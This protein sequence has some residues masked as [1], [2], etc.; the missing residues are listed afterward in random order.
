MR[1]IVG[2]ALA[3]FA[4]TVAVVLLTAIPASAGPG[5]AHRSTVSA[6][7]ANGTCTTVGPDGQI[8]VSAT[9]DRSDPACVGQAL[10]ATV[11]QLTVA[12]RMSAAVIA[13][14]SNDS[15]DCTSSLQVAFDPYSFDNGQYVATL[16]GDGASA[17]TTFTLAMPARTPGTPAATAVPDV[18]AVQ[19]RWIA[20]TESGVSYAVTD[21]SGVASQY[22]AGGAPA[23]DPHDAAGAIA[24]VV[25]APGVH[26]YEIKAERAGTSTLVTSA[27][28]NSVTV[29]ASQSSAS[30]SSGAYSTAGGGG[31][32][33]FSGFGA[34]NTMSELPALPSL[35]PSSDSGASPDS[36]QEPTQRGTYSPTLRYPTK[37]VTENSAISRA[38]NASSGSRVVVDSLAG[39]LVVVLIA[40]HLGA[41]ARRRPE[42]D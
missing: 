26:S 29:S 5:D 7:C 14:A 32:G 1:L 23:V 6:P 3:G 11:V 31:S 19:L 15:A 37:T 9:V 39:G 38:D 28:S 24:T 20:N 42:V 12:S 34:P 30:Q 41:I 18:G 10:D 27:V 40:G 33:S 2:G 17:S 36:T 21:A 13:Q 25:A 22:A 4:S 16:S 8:V 35:S